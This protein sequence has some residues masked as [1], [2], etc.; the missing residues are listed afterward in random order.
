MAERFIEILVPAER[1][2]ELH[3]LIA[4]DE[5]VQSWHEPADLMSA[6]KLLVP[7]ERVE[8]VLDP[9][10]AAFAGDEGFRV[11]V[12][13]VEAALPKRAEPEAAEPEAAP[14]QAE[15]P[16]PPERISREE[17]YEDLSG[18]ARTTRVFLC[19]VVLSTIVAAIGVARNNPAIV[20][21]AMVIAPL[22]GPN[23]ALALATTL[24]D[25]GLAWRALKANGIGLLVALVVAVLAGLLLTISPDATEIAS[26]TQIGPGDLVLALA[27]G[28]AGTLAFTSGVPSALVGVMVAVALL[29]P[30]VVFGM[31]LASGHLG[32]ALGALLLLVCNIVCIN[33]AGV[34][35]FLVQGVQPRRWWEAE[36]SKRMA[37]RALA[38]W[39]VL[40][41]VVAVL[42]L[43][44]QLTDP[45]S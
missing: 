17:L 10:Q 40:L 36:R 14:T 1:A 20:I 27:A 33:L 21:G 34:A 23:A 6:F 5:T 13:P 25:A 2:A 4:R 9:L 18:Y 37:R 39:V 11:V 32:P 22:L 24:G 42:I 35:T 26:R 45:G 44:S 8:A 7:A 3:E 38:I 19:T 16:T 12:L 30:L 31:L 41:F 43:L 28:I 29:P 15:T